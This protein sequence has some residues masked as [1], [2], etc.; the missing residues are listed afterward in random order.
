[1][2]ITVYRDQDAVYVVYDEGEGG[3]IRHAQD[4]S[5]DVAEVPADASELVPAAPF[6]ALAKTWMQDKS[7][8]DLERCINE[9]LEL[10]P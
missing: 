7:T 5:T 1:M 10:L 3:I 2:D 9:L 8:P 6:V 4:G